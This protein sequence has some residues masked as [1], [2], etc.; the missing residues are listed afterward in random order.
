MHYGGRRSLTVAVLTRRCRAPR[1][2]TYDEGMR[3][4]TLLF[5]FA[6]V[7]SQAADY[8]LAV[9]PQTI[10][11]GYYW[12]RA[13]PALKIH[14]GDQVQIQ[15]VS[16]TPNRLLQAGV[17]PEDIPPA[18]KEIYDQMPARASVAR[19]HLVDRKSVV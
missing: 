3:A 8:T 6:A 4:A 13:K 5:L 11:W 7:G 17:K 9:T 10:C 19:G 16:G 12:A 18:L 2:R 15:T 14:S 1:R